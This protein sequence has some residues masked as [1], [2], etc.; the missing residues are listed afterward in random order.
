MLFR[1]T[2]EILKS[3]HDAGIRNIMALRG[4]LP[5]GAGRCGDFKYAVELVSFI[6][7]EFP[8]MA[9]GVAGFPEGHPD[10]PNRFLEMDYL[11]AK[12]EAGADYICTQLFFDNRDF[13]DFRE[14]CILHGIKV[15]VIAGMMPISSKKN[16]YKMAECA[17]GARFP[18]GLL[19]SIKRA[20][21]RDD[22]LANV[23]VQWLSEQ[24]R[25]LLATGVAGL[26]FY[27]MN[28]A[29]CI[30]DVCRYTGISS[31]EAL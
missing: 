11:K 10:T 19:K 3:Y 9:I 16:L 12:V 15:P 24:V 18:A 6:R 28:K 21:D 29:E 23:G 2:A 20:G 5:N 25:D 7:R 22:L 14:R 30:L 1:S 8:E 13:Y 26:H 4:D 17:G 27:T 31:S